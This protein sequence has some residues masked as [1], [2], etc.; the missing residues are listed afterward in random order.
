LT[1]G[2]EVRFGLLG[3]NLNSMDKGIGLDTCKMNVA[4][5]LIVDNLL[6]PPA[7]MYLFLDKVDL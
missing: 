5:L 4:M 3:L 2:I 7:D 1:K 6:E